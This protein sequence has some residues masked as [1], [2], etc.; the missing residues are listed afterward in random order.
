MAAAGDPAREP[1]S[2]PVPNADWI[3]PGDAFQPLYNLCSS[4]QSIGRVSVEKRIWLHDLETAGLV[5][6]F[7]FSGIDCNLRISLADRELALGPAVT[8]H[9]FVE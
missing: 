1:Y 8:R 2:K 4:R 6:V 5:P 3:M 9:I 7:D